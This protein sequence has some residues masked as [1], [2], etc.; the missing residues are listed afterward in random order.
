[1]S[2]PSAEEPELY[3]NA[4]GTPKGIPPKISPAKVRVE[5]SR[6]VPSVQV[7]DAMEPVLDLTCAD[8]LNLAML[9]IEAAGDAQARR[10]D[11]MLAQ[12]PVVTVHHEPNGVI[13]TREGFPINRRIRRR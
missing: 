4:H 11:A 7:L 5:H 8:A 12:Q 10:I 13:V 9:L 3:V 2:G 6:G 1:M